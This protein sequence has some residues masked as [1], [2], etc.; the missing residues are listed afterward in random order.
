MLCLFIDSL[1][2]HTVL[3]PSTTNCPPVIGIQ[4]QQRPLCNYLLDV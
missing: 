3:T 2:P 1:W 4:A